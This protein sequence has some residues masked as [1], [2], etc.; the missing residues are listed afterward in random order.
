MSDWAFLN[1]HRVTEP[2]RTV[3]LQYCSTPADGCN[4]L[5]RFTLHGQLIRVIASDGGGW[6]HIS[7]S[8]EY[9]R[10]PP[11]W[12][13]MC[14]VKDL[15]FEPE[16]VAVQFHPRKSEYVNNH[17]GCLHLWAC[18]DREFPT[19]PSFMVGIKALNV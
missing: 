18:T 10:K 19:P 4:G 1:K 11:T 17:P 8:I 3:P 7:V 2:S 15:F 13:I 5:F 16:E 6:K 9:E 14:R 12:E